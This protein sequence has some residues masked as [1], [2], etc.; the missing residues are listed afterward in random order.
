MLHSTLKKFITSLAPA[1]FSVAMF[2]TYY[3]RAGD[4]VHHRDIQIQQQQHISVSSNAPIGPETANV[5][6]VRHEGEG[7]A[8]AIA[9]QRKDGVAMGAVGYKNPTGPYTNLDDAVYLVAGAYSQNGRPIPGGPPSMILAQEGHFEGQMF[10]AA[11]FRLNPDWTMDFLGHANVPHT[12][13]SDSGEWNFSEDLQTP[14]I[15]VGDGSPEDCIAAPV[16][17]LYLRKGTSSGPRLFIKQT[18]AE[19]HGWV[20]IDN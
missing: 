18:G 8:S 16:G 13:V 17:A 12:T 19:A 2:Q 1:I 20:A 5:S 7:G 6:A 15:K 11:R 10:S 9:F 4:T 3:T 14:H